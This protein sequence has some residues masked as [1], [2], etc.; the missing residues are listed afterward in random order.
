MRAD[1]FERDIRLLSESIRDNPDNPRDVYY[2]AQSYRDLGAYPNALRWYRRRAE[3]DGFEEERW[4]ALLQ[5]AQVMEKTG[6]AWDT[7]LP[8]Y[9]A[10]YTARPSRIEPLC[11][12]A[13]HYR[14]AQQ[15]EIGFAFA[16][17]WGAGFPYPADKLF[18]EKPVYT[19]SM[20]YEYAYC[21]LNTGR[22]L[23]AIRAFEYLQ[24]EPTAPEWLHS[25]VDAWIWDSVFRAGRPVPEEAAIA[26]VAIGSD[27]QAVRWLWSPNP[28]LDHR[29]PIDLLDTGSG[30]RV[31]R[32]ALTAPSFVGS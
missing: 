17:I 26:R 4:Y 29:R 32:D 3:M 27:K 21:A 7:I 14:E 12:I 23:E 5:I 8:A 1:K 30:R 13:K 9:L 20:A 31:V 18:I 28:S 2:L 16:A 25:P 15:F 24:T 22:F 11:S 6:A 19:W 10:A